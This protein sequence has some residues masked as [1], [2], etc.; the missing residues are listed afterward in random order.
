MA[1]LVGVHRAFLFTYMLDNTETVE[2]VETPEVTEVVESTEGVA[3]VAEVVEPTEEVVE[4]TVEETTE[5]VVEETAEPTEV[6]VEP[7]TFSVDD[8]ET[9]FTEKQEQLFAKYDV[10]KELQ[11]YIETLK[12]KTSVETP[13]IFTQIADYGDVEDVTAVLD[14]HN[15][16]YSRREENG[17]YRPNTDQFAQKLVAKSQDIADHLYFDLAS[18]P[19]SKYQGI[20][21]FEEGIAE[22]LA[23]EGDTVN[24]VLNRYHSMMKALK[25]G[26]SLPLADV[27]DFIP[28]EL[29]GAYK[30][31]AKETREEMSLWD[32]ADLYALERAN[33]VNELR[34]IQK[35]IDA[36]VA[37]QQREQQVIQERNHRLTNDAITTETTFFNEVRKTMADKLQSI[38]F[39]SDP[40]LNKLLAHQQVTTLTQAFSDGTEG[41]YARATLAE[42]GINFDHA[43]ARQLVDSVSSA[44][45]ALAVAKHAVDAQGNSLNPVDLKKAQSAFKSVTENWLK[46]ADDILRQEKDLVTTGTATALKAEVEKIKVQPKVRPVAKHIATA[47]TNGSGDRPPA[48]IGYGTPDWDKWWAKKTLEIESQKASAYA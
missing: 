1:Y 21:K 48:S 14:E 5:E 41:E 11:S 12:A 15:T 6:T 38:E 23:V 34:N 9:I 33:K 20:N 29:Y 26:A 35:G 32:D 27:P 4:E 16:L 7:I 3:E 17:A 30:A 44:A 13:E 45:Q 25:E 36:D 47:A 40:K 39:S 19:S 42:A 46:F 37:L 10:P 8:D 18:Q 31:L 24:T 22:A 2:V 43:K 28:A